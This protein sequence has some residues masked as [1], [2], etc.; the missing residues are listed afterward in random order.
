MAKGRGIQDIPTSFLWVYM[1][2]WVYTY[3]CMHMQI[4]KSEYL[5]NINSVWFITVSVNTVCREKGLGENI[6]KM[7]LM[8][9]C[10]VGLQVIIFFLWISQISN[11]LG[12]VSVFLEKRLAP[13][14]LPPRAGRYV[15][16]CTNIPTLSQANSCQLCVRRH[17]R[18]VW[19]SP[20]V[21][22]S[23]SDCSQ[24]KNEFFHGNLQPPHLDTEAVLATL[25]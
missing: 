20:A 23:Q 25:K 12:F 6:P 19:K 2:V 8:G 18:W 9:F 15:W 1:G 7:S 21:C 16:P 5:L 22:F 17:G 24:N 11:V 13:N 4:E 10:K 14:A 3:E